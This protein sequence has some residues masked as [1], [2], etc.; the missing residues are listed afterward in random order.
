MLHIVLITTIGLFQVLN[1]LSQVTSNELNSKL[2]NYRISKLEGDTANQIEAL[3][4]IA[5][6]LKRVGELDSSIR[7]LQKELELSKLKGDTYN[8][9]RSLNALGV[10]E[11]QRGNFSTSEEY[12]SRALRLHGNDGDSLLMAKIHNNL[13]LVQ[14]LEGKFDDAFSN[15]LYSIRIKTD[16]K[17]S[18]SLIVAHN[19]LAL[20]YMEME[21]F[22]EAINQLQLA[23]R[24][25]FDFESDYKMSIIEHNLGISYLGI[26]SIDD[27]ISHLTKAKKTRA[28]FDDPVGKASIDMSFGK[29][30]LH[31]GEYSKAL[32]VLTKVQHV[33]TSKN[34]EK[35]LDELYYLK[36]M[37]FKKLDRLDSASHYYEMSIEQAKKQF[38][39]RFLAD[40][41]KEVAQ[42]KKKEGDLQSSNY[43][44]AKY[45]QV[46]DSLNEL[47][48]R[49][50]ASELQHKFNSKIKEKEIESLE[51]VN[52][53]NERLKK[54]NFW[55]FFVTA[56]LLIVAVVFAVSLYYEMRSKKRVADKLTKTNKS[57]AKSNSALKGANAKAEEAL[58][59]KREFVAFVSHEIRTPLT[60]V[61]GMTE[62]LIDTPLNDKQ[63]KY[64]KVVKNSSSSLLVLLNDILDF[65]KIEA[66]QIKLHYEEVQLK[67]LLSEIKLLLEK[68]MKENVEFELNVDDDLPQFIYIDQ[69]RM[70]QVLVNLLHNAFKFTHKGKVLL[71]V[72]PEKKEKTLN[73][74]LYD[75][76]FQVKDT[77]IGISKD[78]LNWIFESFH[79]ADSSI[80]KNYGGVGLGL[81]IT[82]GLVKLMGSD[83]KVESREG[84]GTTFSFTITSKGKNKPLEN[85]NFT[86]ME[87][88]SNPGKSYPLNILI[89]DENK[90]NREML[91]IQ[92][93]K[94]GYKPLTAKDG[95]EA[96]STAI[97]RKPDLIFMDIM[98]PG[99]DGIEATRK[100]REELKGESPV[101]IALSADT[102]SAKS[103]SSM[104]HTFDDY[105][106]KPFFAEGL[107]ETIKKWYDKT[108][109]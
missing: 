56:I 109:A 68:E 92:L 97:N 61:I 23:K 8:Y 42:L 41:Y 102:F 19:N 51:K 1:V 11:K 44:L 63:K 100:I 82:K 70:R 34:A 75:I 83:L 36:A 18:A 7:Y 59:I 96:I 37:T 22:N 39:S 17:D 104:I 101:I 30:W 26:N 15:F 12:Y 40:S 13:G 24:A 58:Q 64:L 95:E 77:G 53:L 90:I 10:V 93:R 69:N 38:G 27:A 66:K 28:S 43:Y 16:L 107:L 32:D 88:D 86:K 91:D 84:E 35:L 67:T 87:D 45:I 62:L 85:I 103:Q 89:V 21:D 74:Y 14:K 106:S 98:M 47:E 108:K 31:E 50:K 6:D 20:L 78:K 49:K 65:S 5:V 9:I 48:I 57:L 46:Q 80:S 25:C 94:M 73:G 71:T 79:Q 55:F 99:I 81:S 105:M 3:H 72:K 76:V 54:R 4:E 29:L 2:E 33:F 60:S 52:H